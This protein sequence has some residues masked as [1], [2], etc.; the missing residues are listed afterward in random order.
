MVELF[1]LNTLDL[2]KNV[3]FIV[4]N[5][6]FPD[7]VGSIYLTYRIIWYE[8]LTFLAFKVRLF[9]YNKFRIKFWDIGLLDNE[10]NSAEEIDGS[11][12]FVC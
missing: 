4:L 9:L 7:G 6:I 3:V 2:T 1:I 11:C 10:F 12:P 5:L 8:I